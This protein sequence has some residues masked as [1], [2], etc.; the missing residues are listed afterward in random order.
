M[1]GRLKNT[2]ATVES[3]PPEL[4]IQPKM[5]STKVRGPEWIQRNLGVGA[6]QGT[7]NTVQGTGFHRSAR[8]DAHDS[9]LAKH[10]ALASSRLVIPIQLLF[11]PLISE[12]GGVLR[13][14]AIGST[15]IKMVEANGNQS[16]P[17]EYS[18]NES[19]SY[20]KTES[21]RD[22]QCTQRVGR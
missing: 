9:H 16:W 18:S 10:D 22:C 17:W 14:R 19:S 11:L 2:G 3:Q 12:L 7:R 5:G 20:R 6:A 4:G 8:K 21:P 15:S 1:P 13:R